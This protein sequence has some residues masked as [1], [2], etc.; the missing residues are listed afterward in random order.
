[1]VKYKVTWKSRKV[2]HSRY[3]L[4]EREEVDSI[5]KDTVEEALEYARQCR[6]RYHVTKLTIEVLR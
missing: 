6:S 2:T 1:M 5:I 4:C 3:G